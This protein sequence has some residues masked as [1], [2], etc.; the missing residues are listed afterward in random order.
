MKRDPWL[1]QARL[2]QTS[3]S[4]IIVAAIRIVHVIPLMCVL[5]TVDAVQDCRNVILGGI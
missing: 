1:R 2:W 4:S 3:K 5:Y